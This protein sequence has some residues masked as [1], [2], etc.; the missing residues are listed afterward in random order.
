M[1]G[2]VPFVVDF[3]GLALGV[4]M[5]RAIFNPNHILIDACISSSNV[6]LSYEAYKFLPIAINL[7]FPRQY[8]RLEQKRIVV[9]EYKSFNFDSIDQTTECMSNEAAHNIKK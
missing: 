8:K 6:M 2:H 5:P 1:R 3:I 7:G 4:L 9:R